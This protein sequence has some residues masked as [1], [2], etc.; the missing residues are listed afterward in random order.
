M[1]LT[2]PKNWRG[3]LEVP[4]MSSVSHTSGINTTSA[5]FASKFEE[6]PLGDNAGGVGGWNYTPHIVNPLANMFPNSKSWHLFMM[7]P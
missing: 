7:N 5:S 2:T 1:V 3:P 4:Y 6:S